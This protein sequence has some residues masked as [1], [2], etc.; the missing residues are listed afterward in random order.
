MTQLA[1][2]T[3]REVLESVPEL[4]GRVFLATAPGDEKPPLSVFAVDSVITYP[5]LGAPDLVVSVDFTVTTVARSAKAMQDL[6]EKV[7]E[8]F[9]KR[10][11]KIQLLNFMIEEMEVEEGGYWEAIATYRVRRGF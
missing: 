1:T 2:K 6:S 3:V 7:H 9:R 5:K 4:A 10:S 11:G 8:A